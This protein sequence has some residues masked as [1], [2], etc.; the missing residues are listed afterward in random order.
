[1][2]VTK[3][4]LTVEAARRQ[5]LNRQ[6][7][8]QTRDLLRAWIDGWNAI[9]TEYEAAT[10]R[11]LRTRSDK[12]RLARLEQAHAVMSRQLLAMYDATG[13]RITDDVRVL[14]E[15]GATATAG[16]VSTQL[17]PAMG[18]TF[19]R[20]SPGQLAAITA[21]TSQRITSQLWA[22]SKEASA[23]MRKQLVLGVAEGLNPRETARRIIKEAGDTFNGGLSRALVITRTETLDAHRAASAAQERAHRDVVEKWMWYA[24]LG[25]RTCISC[26][27]MHG[28]EFP[29]DVDGPDDHQQG[30]CA[31]VPVTKTWEELG[32]VGIPET[33]AVPVSGADWFNA[34]PEAVQR[35]ILGPARY[36]AWASGDYPVSEWSR[37]RSTDG[38][39]DSRVPSPA[40]A[41]TVGA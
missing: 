23:V 22:L 33:R 19:N 14:V 26:I 10:R 16:M 24:D 4:V 5:L 37:V 11:A 40:P 20:V 27:A 34:Q 12:A 31:R 7:D 8:R 32:F 17:P 41:C 3:D 18:V 15:S 21:R 2:A 38:W 30:R 35:R 9:A 28:E 13:A 25:P 36:Q 6:L 1:M 39:R 29:L